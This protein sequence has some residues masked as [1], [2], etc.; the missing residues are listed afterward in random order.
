MVEHSL[1]LIIASFVRKVALN[2]AGRNLGS[3]PHLWHPK[4]RLLRCD[5]GMFRRLARVHMMATIYNNSIDM[6][7]KVF[8]HLLIDFE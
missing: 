7:D 4:A 1:A 6:E 8:N 3:D 5:A 2:Q